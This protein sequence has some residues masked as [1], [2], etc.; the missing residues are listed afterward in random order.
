MSCHSATV[1]AANNANGRSMRLAFGHHRRTKGEFIHRHSLRPDTA[2]SVRRKRRGN[3]GTKR[4]GVGI[5][6]VR[7]WIGLRRARDRPGPGKT[8]GASPGKPPAKRP[9]LQGASERGVGAGSD[10]WAY[11]WE[12]RGAARRCPW[13]ESPGFLITLGKVGTPR[14]AGNK[15]SPPQNPNRGGGILTLQQEDVSCRYRPERHSKHVHL[16]SAPAFH[17]I[18]EVLWSQLYIPTA[19]A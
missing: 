7:L 5:R 4:I 3:R 17:R 1:L 13:R 11:W 18:R 8:S 16:W 10:W 2:G 15:S 19:R 14:C 6:E 9:S 12:G